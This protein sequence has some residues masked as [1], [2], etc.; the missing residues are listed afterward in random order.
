[1]FF[2]K[3]RVFKNSP[4][5]RR[6]FNTKF[7]VFQKNS[8]FSKIPRSRDGVL[9]QNSVFFK[10]FRVFKNSPFEKVCTFQKVAFFNKIRFVGINIWVSP[11]LYGTFVILYPST[12][13]TCKKQ[14]FNR[15]ISMFDINYRDQ[16]VLCIAN[17]IP[18]GRLRTIFRTF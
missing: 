3:F 18:V 14:A 6:S 11:I 2:K 8:V 15:T 5:E 13:K 17:L 16:K 9:T 7:R 12:S 10:K 4:F 1:M